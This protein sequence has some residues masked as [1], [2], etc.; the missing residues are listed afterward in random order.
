MIELCIYVYR[1]VTHLSIF[2]AQQTAQETLYKITS[3]IQ[4]ERLSHVIHN[5]LGSQAKFNFETF[6]RELISCLNDECP[7][8]AE[9]LRYVCICI[10]D[11]AL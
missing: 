7:E 8:K 2:S 9:E 3:V 6:S 5:N 1:T 11:N 10:S 4:S